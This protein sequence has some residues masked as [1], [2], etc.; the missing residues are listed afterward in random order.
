MN[1]RPARTALALAFAA[2]LLGTACSPKPPEAAM[3]SPKPPDVAMAS[4]ASAAG[5]QVT[6]VDVTE[7]VKTALHQDEML[8]G[9]DITVVTLNG[10]VR[11][12][13]IVD[14]Q[15]QIDKAL[16]VARA[17]QGA[18]TIHDEMTLKK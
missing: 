1:T 10:D 17:A 4:P 6:D 7:H 2:A 12:Q 13:G 3:T 15:A 18:H 8:K 11:L 14:S 5:T 9:F 16:Q